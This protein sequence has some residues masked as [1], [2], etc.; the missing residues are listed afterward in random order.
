MDEL[1]IT[2]LGIGH[3]DAILLRWT[4]QNKQW[5]CLIDG[6][7]SL[8]RLIACLDEEQVDE[9]DL[10]VL[11]HL[12]SDHACG[13]IGLA[14]KKSVKEFWGPALPAFQRHLW[15]FGEKGVQAIERGEELEDSLKSKNVDICYPLEGYTML[16]FPSV[17]NLT[18]I[19]PPSKLF[20]KLL[21]GDSDD[22]IELFSQQ[23]MPL[24]WL[25]E[26]I[27]E[28]SEEQSAFF[29]N[30]DAALSRN[31]LTPDDLQ[32]L[33]ESREGIRSDIMRLSEEWA[34]NTKTEPEFFGDSVLN[35]TSLVLYLEVN[36]N[37]RIHKGLFP[38]DQ[39]NWTYLLARNSRG[40]HADIFKASHHG[41]QIYIES[42][43]SSHEELF[44]SIQPK[45]VL[46]SANGQHNLPRNSVRNSAI[47]WGS[48]IVC[49]CYRNIEFIESINNNAESCH[50]LHNCTE[51]RNVTIILNK[52]GIKS[53]TPACFSG[54]GRHFGPIIQI[55][56]HVVD[57]SPIVT[58]LYEHE[59]R[60][61]I[62]WVKNKLKE[63]HESRLEKALFL[64]EG[65]Q[66]ITDDHIVTL[67]RQE[68]RAILVPHLSQILNEGM[69][70]NEFWAKNKCSEWQSYQYPT[71]K[72]IGEY[73]SLLE[74]KAMILFPQSIG[75]V[76]RD[77]NSLILNLDITGLASYADATLRFPS[78]MFQDSFWPEVAKSFKNKEWHC[79]IHKLDMVAFSRYSIESLLEKILSGSLIE[80][81]NGAYINIRREHFPFCHPVLVSG[82]NNKDKKMGDYE[83][84]N[85]VEQC[86]TINQKNY[87]QEEWE[88]FIQRE[89]SSYDSK[90]LY[91][92]NLWEY[93]GKNIIK[94]IEILKKN[95]E[96][97]W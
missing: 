32:S 62:K 23:P 75:N 84:K 85:C 68:N 33:P 72:D 4:N 19:S 47:R 20:R 77:T 9:I 14:K 30:L 94:C 45:V 31:F 70:R 1:Q 74:Q 37:G 42:N 71:K 97:L 34:R 61:H 48:T 5:T 59:L 16:P 53:E 57:P 67:A 22:V 54:F 69:R 13:L 76:V 91:I 55:R 63:I 39:E 36:T 96:Q 3:G 73:L 64:T 11:S 17:G 6:G 65:S 86:I 56:Q 12:D 29:V 60:R 52:E 18:V 28:E 78:N 41:G 2:T 82:K 89:G 93:S 58:H 49:T 10:V 81:Y 38:G 88:Q 80:G 95:F 79:F 21:T 92:N 8:E 40:L 66:P 43:Q 51:A 83:Q 26:P 87:S 46:I 90:T 15:L 7:P 50:A 35:N 25:Q 44:S 27:S 24:G